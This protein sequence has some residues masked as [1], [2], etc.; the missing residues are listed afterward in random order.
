[1][2]ET[3]ARAVGVVTAHTS[4]RSYS[5]ID[6]RTSLL[7]FPSVRFQTADGRTVEF[8]N[9]IGTNAPP[10]VGDEVTVIYDPARP[11]EAKVALGSMFRINPKALLVAGAIFLAAM[12]FFFLF[13]VA[14]IVWVSLS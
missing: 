7:F 14:V 4:R 5:G 1:M 2:S 9:K 13:F 8:Q 12:A 6:K 10:R 3:E 11:E